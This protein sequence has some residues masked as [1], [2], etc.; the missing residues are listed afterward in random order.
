M[1]ESGAS[2]SPSS[3]LEKN[4]SSCYTSDRFLDPV[5]AKYRI[6]FHVNVLC[7]RFLVVSLVVS[8]A[9]VASYV[10][11]IRTSAICVHIA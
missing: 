2:S 6:C 3:P 1:A 8:I 4:V 7:C 5:T 11:F 10:S 9:T